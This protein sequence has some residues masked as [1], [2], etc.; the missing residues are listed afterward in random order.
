VAT[1]VGAM[2]SARR[3]EHIV[4]Q[5]GINHRTDDAELT[6][7]EIL[8]MEEKLEGMC[9][10]TSVLGIS[11][12]ASLG[13]TAKLNVRRMND[14]LRQGHPLGFIPPIGEDEVK[15]VHWDVDYG[16]HHD[17]GTVAK[18]MSSIVRHVEALN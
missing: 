7:Q 18:I 8:R 16:I 14:R 5:A 13:A 12:P 10:N 1:M 9:C 4:V 6:S 2:T 17:A 3:L 15:I 11:V